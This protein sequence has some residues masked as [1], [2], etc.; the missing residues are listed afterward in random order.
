MLRTCLRSHSAAL[1]GSDAK[2]WADVY[3]L[4]TPNITNI[5]LE[6]Y[7]GYHFQCSLCFCISVSFPHSRLMAE[8]MRVDFSGRPEEK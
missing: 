5:L 2:S 8:L 3:S 1:L 4:R 7:L 6:Y